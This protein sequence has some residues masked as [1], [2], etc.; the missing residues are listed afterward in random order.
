MSTSLD[1]STDLL[2]PLKSLRSPRM[3]CHN[4]L[5]P[6]FN[7]ATKARSQVDSAVQNTSRTG[8]VGL[9]AFNGINQSTVICLYCYIALNKISGCL[10]GGL[11]HFLFSH[12]LGI[13]IP[14]DFHIFQRGGPGPPTS[15][16]L[17]LHLYPH[18]YFVECFT[19]QSF[20][21]LR[22]W[23]RCQL[24][25]ANGLPILINIEWRWIYYNDL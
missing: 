16:M 9:Y 22:C 15:C 2:W 20:Q 19:S 4:R 17:V 6:Y 13:I 3:Y 12:I 25:P 18:P 24:R 23:R 10:V 21:A 7:D 1:K 8:C 11:E 5:V 14:T